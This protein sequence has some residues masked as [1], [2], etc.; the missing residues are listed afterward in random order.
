MKKVAIFGASET[1]RKVYKTIR[2]E[3][4]V[5]AFIDNNKAKW[6]ETFEGIEVIAPNDIED[7]D[8]D[9]VI[10][11]TLP[12]RVAVGRQLQ[13]LLPNNKI[14]NQFIEV[15]YRARVLFMRSF[16]EIVYRQGLEG[17]VAEGGV[18]QGE[19]AEEINRYF[20]DR[21]FFLFDT[22]EGF[23]A[24]DVATDQFRHHSSSSTGTFSDTSVDFVLRRLPHPK[25]AVIRPGRFPDS[26][27]GLEAEQFCFVN[28]DFDLY[29]PILAGLKFFWD[30]MVPGGVILVHD[31]FSDNYSGVR[32]AVEDFLTTVKPRPAILPIGDDYSIAIARP[33]V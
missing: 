7:I 26:S 4:K 21:K 31:Y 10:I 11:A 12:G 15:F 14:N 13:A 29:E 8:V 17:A 27:I 19:F 32:V 3:A 33:P 28:L 5:L 22:F 9:E 6:G 18:Y 1:G 23:A 20:P 16:A 25:Q 24:E 30:K 2:A